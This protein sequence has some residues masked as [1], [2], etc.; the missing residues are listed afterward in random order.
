M[1]NF[2]ISERIENCSYLKYCDFENG[3]CEWS[4]SNQANTS[5]ATLEGNNVLYSKPLIGSNNYLM[6]VGEQTINDSYCG[7]NFLLLTS[8]VNLQVLV[9]GIGIV[10]SSWSSDSHY[11][12]ATSKNYSQW[13]NIAVYLDINQVDAVNERKIILEIFADNSVLDNDNQYVAIDNIT[14]QPC[15]NCEAKGKSTITHL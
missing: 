1:I 13:R 10:W 5:I 11:T 12:T 15:I 4:L 9:T 7:V 2:V 14:L 3:V 8:N 6:T